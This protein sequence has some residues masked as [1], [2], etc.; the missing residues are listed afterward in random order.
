MATTV[1][2][3]SVIFSGNVVIQHFNFDEE[4]EVYFSGKMSD[5]NECE[6]MNLLSA[7]VYSIAPKDSVLIVDICNHDIVPV[8]KNKHLA[9]FL[10]LFYRLKAE[11][12]DLCF[13]HE[14]QTD[15]ITIG[16]YFN[17]RKNPIW[18]A[19]CY[20]NGRIGG[21]WP[22]KQRNDSISC[23]LWHTL[24]KYLESSVD[25]EESFSDTTDPYAYFSAK[26]KVKENT[27]ANDN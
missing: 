21:S 14:K 8:P 4:A 17:D 7:D 18:Y 12:P 3:L 26:L 11:R 5:L 25:Y 13:E 22:L 24:H 2:D 27:N 19:K 10:S 9:D 20:E 1:K 6:F 16:I 23:R 15:G